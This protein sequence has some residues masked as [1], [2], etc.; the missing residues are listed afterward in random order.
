MKP[1]KKTFFT[2]LLLLLAAL[3]KGQSVQEVWQHIDGLPCEEASA[4]RQGSDGYM[5]IGTRLGLIRYDGYSAKIYRNNVSHPY[6]FSS[7]DI[8]C[9][10]FDNDCLYAGSFFGL[11]GL[12][13][14]TQRIRIAHFGGSD[15]IQSLLCDSSGRLW[16]GT[17]AGLFKKDGNNQYIRIPD[18]PSKAIS[19]LSET[20]QGDVVVVTGSDG[21]FR[22]DK[23]GECLALAGTE[24][25]SPRA[26][27]TDN[28]G[29]LWIGTDR[30]GLYS[31]TG[32]TLRHHAGFDY[33]IVNDM[34]YDEA[35]RELILATDGGIYSNV[36]T[37]VSL[38][39][40]NVRS[41]CMDRNGNV[42]AATETQGVYRRQNYSASFR[43]ER[44]AFL[45]QTCPIMSQFDVTNLSDS[46]IWNTI[47]RINALYDNGTGTTYVGTAG[48]GFHEISGGRV[49]RHVTPGNSS[50]LRVGDIYAFCTLASDSTLI[51][52][53]Y[54]LYLLERGG[55]GHFVGRIG[56]SDI[57]TM[58]TLSIYRPREG[59]LWLG[60]VGG[61]AHIRGTRLSDARVT[62][63]THINKKGIIDPDDAGAI[64]D[65]H[66]ETGDYQLGGIFRIAED[67]HGR[68]WACTSEPGLLLYDA[69][70]D[71]FRSVS[72]QL[73]IP[74]DNVHSMDIDRYGNFWMTTSYGILQMSAEA[75]GRP[76]KM[77]LYTTSDGL[78]ANYF[79]STKS[80][81][82][83]D[84]SVCFLNRQHLIRVVPQ[85]NFG[86]SGKPQAY[87]SDIIVNGAS[88]DNDDKVLDAAPPY[89][90]RIVLPYDRNDLTIRLSSLL[91]GR[92]SSLRYSYMLEDYDKEFRQTDM[93]D[94]I[95]RYNLLSPG[96]YRFLYH[97][98]EGNNAGDAHEQ[99][100]EIEIL[101]PLWWRWWARLLYAIASI[102]VIAAFTRNLRDRQRRK[103]QLD[104]L[105]IEKKEQEFFYKQ[106]L[107]F[108]TKIIHEFLTPLTL[109]SDLSHS[110]HEKVRPSLQATLFML[111]SQVD[112]LKDAMSNV[113]DTKEDV[114]F[115]EALQ[116]ARDM[117]QVDRDFLNRCTESVNRHIADTGYNHHVM[118]SE[119]GASHATLYRKLKAL[120]GMDATSFIRSIRM[121]AACQILNSNPNIRIGELAEQVGYNNPRY[122]S[123]CFKTEFGMTPREY[124]S[125]DSM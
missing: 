63:Y 53:W 72:G 1:M 40:A 11:N 6:T 42:W 97:P 62:L 25:I 3:L 36:E 125:Q 17:N 22:I 96:R 71:A 32:E 66:D 9:L 4:V 43:T 88:V 46:S 49:V 82:L 10:A 106:R 74:G 100:L 15:F 108:Y 84:G 28:G 37:G 48:D 122:F 2:A 13:L 60:L 89:T 86:I 31:L 33:C 70:K 18:I 117:T 14:R 12:D 56:K 111:T 47:P 77:Q 115:S 75:D 45:R 8:K 73:G 90:H 67:R 112:R 104:I 80:T 85:N 93:G 123:T 76:A 94:N 23:R 124:L 44:P 16:V 103:Q 83:S 68:I 26:T 21:I 65:T 87:I 119:V 30:K 110:L 41:L 99:V 39:G 107:S 64:T 58:H 92:E 54:G 19:H 109:M 61:I 116:K 50:W 102:A 118:M 24:A 35:G 120:T 51:G 5:W 81:L 55:R 38:R 20:P 95:A 79:G 29:T 105:R 57:S 27:Y 7:C 59:H 121:R 69:E 91:F 113:A 101:H 34:L 78:P 98:I 114:S 52:T